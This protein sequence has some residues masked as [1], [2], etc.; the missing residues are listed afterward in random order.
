MTTSVKPTPWPDLRRVEHRD[1]DGEVF[2]VE[3]KRVAMPPRRTRRPGGL[4]GLVYMI[5]CAVAQ[6]A[7]SPA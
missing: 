1:D 3:Y 7:R 2:W 6:L 5:G 4:L